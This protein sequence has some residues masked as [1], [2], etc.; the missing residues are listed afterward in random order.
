[1]QLFYE[2][3]AKKEETIFPV[4]YRIQKKA[5]SLQLSFFAQ[6]SYSTL[7]P[8]FKSPHSN[9]TLPALSIV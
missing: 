3:S 9:A 8:T 7:K 2:K 4:N 5:A 6:I 1:M